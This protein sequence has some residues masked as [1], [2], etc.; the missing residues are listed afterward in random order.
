MQDWIKFKG[1]QVIIVFEGC[2]AAGKGGTIRAY[3]LRLTVRK[4]DLTRWSLGDD[5]PAELPERL[6]SAILFIYLTG[7]RIG[8]VKKYTW[9]EIDWKA[10]VIR[11]EKQQAK[12]RKASEVPLPAEVVER[13]Q[14]VPPSERTGKLF[15]LGCFR[16]AWQ[17]ACCR[18]GLGRLDKSVKN[19]KGQV[20]NGGYGKYSGLLEHD[21]R[22]STVRNVS[23]D[24]TPDVQG[25]LVTGHRDPKV[26]RQYCIATPEDAKLAVSNSAAKL[27]DVL[28]KVSSPRSRMGQV[29][30][31]GKRRR[32]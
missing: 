11:V 9:S 8:E 29:V 19:A 2:D 32:A 27:S 10:S 20:V 22:R 5:D 17:S 1:L 15:P 6:R 26:Y 12:N 3:L 21:L 13:L 31:F 30:K 23:L 16:K 28:E 14:K 25:M 24:G 18:A 4:H 7:R